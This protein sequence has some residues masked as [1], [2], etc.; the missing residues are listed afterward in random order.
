MNTIHKLRPIMSDIINFTGNDFELENALKRITEHVVNKNF[1]YRN[2]YSITK[3][4]NITENFENQNQ[5]RSYYLESNL[6]N[7]NLKGTGFAD[8]VFNKVSFK[9]CMTEHSSFESSYLFN[10]YFQN[11]QPY[12]S[13][14]FAKSFICNSSFKN[15]LFDRCRLSDSTFTQSTIENCSFDNTLFDGT[16]FDHTILDSISFKNLNLE[17][18]QFNNV[19]INN[20]ALPFPTIPF[21]IN[22]LNYLMNTSD[23]VFVKSAKKGQI[24]KEEYLDLLPY[25]K[26]F[27]QKTNHYFP[28]ANIYIAEKNIKDAFETIKSGIYQSIILNNYR[29]IKNYCILIKSCNLFDMHQK[30]LLEKNIS[31]EFNNRLLENFDFYSHLVNNFTELSN[32]LLSNSYPSLI[33]SFKTNIEND[34]Y[35]VLSLFYR[36]LDLLLGIVGIKSNYSVSFTYNSEAEIIATINSLEPSVVVALIT[37]FTS[38][39]ISGLKGIAYLPDVIEKFS[40][41]KYK[42]QKEKN[43]LEKQQL[44][45]QKMQL[46]ISKMRREIELNA[47]DTEPL[48]QMISG[49]EPVLANCD[50]LNNAGVY[51]NDI[52]YNAINLNLENLTDSISDMIFSDNSN[53]NN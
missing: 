46:E 51:V 16:V 28:L 44:E 10:C 15:I 26:T 18:A 27:Y 21:I 36:T 47:I 22:G 42:I 2:A 13:V 30:K 4:Q 31:Q 53:V 3:N 35:L 9:N 32:I 33:V 48:D 25:L 20:T 49:I 52:N 41:I 14:S 40:T 19:H 43:E 17:Y 37:A 50:E 39:F 23:K 12:V 11:E 6:R 29:Q 5:R 8:S 7:C 24:S 1:Y 34:N 38:I 45:N